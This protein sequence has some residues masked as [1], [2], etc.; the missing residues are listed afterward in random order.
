MTET[1]APKAADFE[2]AIAPM[3]AELTAT[4]IP[5]APAITKATPK[6]EKQP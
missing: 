5:A 2:A 6:K 3:S 4:H 1:L